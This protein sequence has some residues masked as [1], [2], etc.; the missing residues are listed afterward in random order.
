[1]ERVK[2]SILSWIRISRD[3]ALSDS[4]RVFAYAE[5]LGLLKSSQGSSPRESL[6]IS[7]L[8]TPPVV[9]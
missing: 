4:L 5:E 6:T 2:D 7:I 3:Y 8:R 1:M 9:A